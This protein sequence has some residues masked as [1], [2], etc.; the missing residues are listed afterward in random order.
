[1]GVAEKHRRKGIASA[2]LARAM[3][4]AHDLGAR[5]GSASTQLWNQAAHATYAKAGFQPHRLV[6]GRSLQF[7]SQPRGESP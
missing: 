6:V 5:F 1:M 3:A 2:L 7:E 4:E